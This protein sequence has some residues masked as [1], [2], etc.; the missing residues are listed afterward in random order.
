MTAG[1]FASH[2]HDAQVFWKKL[3][4]QE[5]AR[6]DFT[7][8]KGQ[9]PEQVQAPVLPLTYWSASCPLSHC[10]LKHNAYL[11]PAPHEWC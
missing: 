1:L 2:L 9:Y 11:W 3:L 7:F 10:L 6:P 8:K 5:G 4:R